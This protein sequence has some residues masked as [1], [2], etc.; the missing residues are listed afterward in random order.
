MGGGRP[1]RHARPGED[2]SFTIDDNAD[3]PDPR[4]GWQPNGVTG[5]SRVV[6]HNDF[7]WTDDEYQARPLSS[8]L[9]YELHI[10]TF[11]P[12]GTFDSAIAKLAHLKSLGV[13]HVELMPV[14]DFPG[15]FGWGYDGVALFAPRQEYGGPGGVEAPG[16]RLP[17][18]Q[19]RRLSSTSCTTTWGRRATSCRSSPPTSPTA[20]TPPG[21][22]RSTSTARTAT[23]SA[24][25]SATT[26]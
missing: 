7:D 25:S 1:E 9:I 11:T 2:Y 12:E 26:P 21:A 17:R 10:G 18:A 24:G 20:T 4:S 5:P 13:T 16:R 19:A 22:T 23:R 14:N 15:K 8:A 3:L 6:D